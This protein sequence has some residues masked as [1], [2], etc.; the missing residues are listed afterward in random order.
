MNKGLNEVTEKAGSLYMK[1]GRVT[2]EVIDG[3]V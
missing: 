2:A 3:H 1:A